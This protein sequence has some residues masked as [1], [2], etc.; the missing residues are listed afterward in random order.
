MEQVS[1][2]ALP[3]I[4]VGGKKV[5]VPKKEKRKFHQALNFKHPFESLSDQVHL[6]H[7]ILSGN[8]IIKLKIR[9]AIIEL[10]N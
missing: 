10:C 8:F 2:I 7:D 4:S 5:P 9:Y 1:S 3:R 6:H